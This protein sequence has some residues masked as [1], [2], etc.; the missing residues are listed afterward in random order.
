MPRMEHFHEMRELCEECPV[1]VLCAQQGLASVGGFYAGVWVPWK[2]TT[3]ESDETRRIRDR[4]R[5]HLK[6]I[7]A[8]AKPIKSVSS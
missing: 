8:P 4:A 7:A 1:L 5:A 3:T 2:G 6:R